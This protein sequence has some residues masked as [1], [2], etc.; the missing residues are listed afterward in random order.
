MTAHF[1]NATCAVGANIN[2]GFQSTVGLSTFNGGAMMYPTCEIQTA[3]EQNFW[4]VLPKFIGHLAEMFGDLL[5]TAGNKIGKLFSSS[6]STHTSALKDKQNTHSKCSSA[7]VALADLLE[8]CPANS[9]CDIPP[10]GVK[11]VEFSSRG[12]INRETGTLLLN[13]AS[14]DQTH[15]VE[16]HKKSKRMQILA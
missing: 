9:Q 14:T 12:E 13:D 2:T 4:Y 15:S 6:E 7:L 8:V 11:A 1:D 10:E 5:G 3:P 16:P